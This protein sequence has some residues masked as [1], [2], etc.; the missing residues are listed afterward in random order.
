M[1]NMKETRGYQ[2]KMV[3]DNILQ[4]NAANVLPRPAPETYEDNEQLQPL[5]FTQ[6]IKP[7]PNTSTLIIVNDENNVLNYGDELG[8]FTKAGLLVGSFFYENAMM[9][10]LIFGDDETEEGVDG[11]LA[12]EEYIFKVWDSVLDEEREV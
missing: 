6:N 10:G 9:G 7:N 8:V 5:H 12:D 11:I 4:Y 1:G 3:Q 2:V